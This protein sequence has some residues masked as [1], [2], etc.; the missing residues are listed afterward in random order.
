[1]AEFIAKTGLNWVHPKTGKKVRVES[2]H[3][4]DDVPEKSRGWLL[5]QGLIEDVSP[6]SKPEK[7]EDA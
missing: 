3:R 2:G 6:K 4:C 1:M 7:D 5:D